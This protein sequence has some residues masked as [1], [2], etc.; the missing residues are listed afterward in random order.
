VH[1]EKTGDTGD[2]YGSLCGS[3]HDDPFLAA[4]FALG[5]S[6]FVQYKTE[7]AKTPLAPL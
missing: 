2:K 4:T 6:G 7:N 3:R 1:A 5:S